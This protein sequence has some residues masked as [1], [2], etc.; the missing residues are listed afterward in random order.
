M[1]KDAPGTAEQNFGDLKALY[2]SLVENL[3]LHVLRKDVEGHF[4]FANGLF[5]RLVG[6]SL[7]ELI[8]LTDFDLYPAELA[9]KYRA[10]DQH[11]MSTGELLELVEENQQGDR[12]EYVQVM[13]SAVRNARDEIVGV[14]VVFWEITKRKQAELALEQERY[15]LHALMDNLPHNIYFKDREC[16]FIRINRALSDCFRLHDASGAI[17]RTDMDFFTEEHALQAL[18]DEQEIMRTRQ[19]MLDREEKETW[20]DGHTTWAASTKMPLYDDRGN[21]VGT[22]G[23]SRDITKQKEAEIALRMS[24]MRYRTLYDSSRDA[25]M[26]LTPETGFLA[27]NAAAIQL[28]GCRDETHFTSLTPA[29]LS[30]ETQ[31]DGVASSIK[32]QEMMAIAMRDG[33]NFFEWTHRRADGGLFDASV[34][35]T[36]MELEGKPIL[37]ATVRDITDQKRAAE[38][39]RTAKEDAEAA[40]RAKSEF[41]ARMSHEI[42]TPMN[43]II[44]MT[45]LVLDTQLNKSQ[46]E[47]LE[48]VR[49]SADSLLAVINDILDFSRIE[50]GKLSLDESPFSLRDSLGD[51]MKSLAFRAHNKELELACRI[52]PEVPDIITADAGRL[53]QVIVNLV[54]N[55]IKF[56]ETGEVVLSVEQVDRSGNFVTLQFQVADTGIGIPEDKRASIFDAFEQADVSRT[57]KHGGTGLG[58]AISRRLAEMMGGQLWLDL[59][60]QEGSTFYF[61]IRCGVTEPARAVPTRR[62][63]N[64]LEGARVLVVDDNDTNRRILE[65]LLTNWTMVPQL[66]DSAP[67]ALKMLQQAESGGRPF[68]LV[69][70]DVHMPVRDGFSLVEEIRRHKELRSTIIMMLTSGD[71]PEDLDHCEQLGVAAYLLKP[72]KQSEL[73]DAIM[74]AIGIEVTDVTPRGARA[75]AT[76]PRVRPLSILLAEDSLVNQRVAVALLAKHDHKVTVANDGQET[77]ELWEA[78]PFDLVLMDVQMP[79][80]DGYEACRQIRARERSTGRH[81]PVVAMTAHALKGD[82]ERCLEAG[83]DDYVSKPVHAQRLFEAIAAQFPG[84]RIDTQ[85]GPLPAAEMADSEGIVDW[86]KALE[87]LQGEKALLAELVQVAFEEIP[88]MVASVREAAEEKDAKA[89]RLAAHKLRGSTRYFDQPKIEKQALEIEALASDGRMDEL[90]GPLDH[91]DYLCRRL[92]EAMSDFMAK[93]HEA[94]GT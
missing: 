3:P 13:K 52:H 86:A 39:L 19:P 47:Y 4:T 85:S 29:D 69:L 2:S 7:D 17:G 26:T 80:M 88:K 68:H 93:S 56:T 74:H 28:F 58:L 51:T 79:L 57:R 35:L 6:K 23:V 91:L 53:R 63:I 46:K 75:Y 27:G 71:Q 15:L 83:M 94:D 77:V 38:A 49:E 33:S 55:A 11:V 70:T 61:T 90:A 54:G 87:G 34:L 82:R 81:T 36:R 72:I 10:D 50:A 41:L 65:E 9:K 25:I 92:L 67:A 44:G 20:R 40:S 22:F 89:I 18:N 76:M 31:P 5:C 42:R 62:E 73:F 64:M 84:S 37:Q 8:G 12:T 48:L 60:K 45:E 78:Q 24:E 32:A 16:R 14:Q 59:E 1:Q 30:P 21:V 43:A 66:A